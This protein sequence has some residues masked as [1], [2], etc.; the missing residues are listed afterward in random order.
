[1]SQAA[2]GIAAVVV[3]VGAIVLTLVRLVAQDEARR[4][5]RRRQRQ[6]AQPRPTSR[7]SV[8][9][10]EP[11]PGFEGPLRSPTRRPP[12]GSPETRTAFPG[13][14][15]AER[16]VRPV[17]KREDRTRTAPKDARDNPPTIEVPRRHF[18]AAAR[19]VTETQF[20]STAMLQRRLRLDAD[21][22][23]R[24]M[25]ALEGAG[26]VGPATGST[27]R[28]VLITPDQLTA[29]FARLGI[30]EHTLPDGTN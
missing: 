6:P 21:L 24:L 26:I 5:R 8:A 16:A 9:W 14:A 30:G 13:S 10:H 23:A 25:T 2:P 27:A 17:E 15:P 7:R 1:M 28:D 19:L 29:V 4:T 22:A 11:P 20:G 3:A 18:A 12:I